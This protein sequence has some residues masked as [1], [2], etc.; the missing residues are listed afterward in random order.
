MVEL[1]QLSSSLAERKRR[2]SDRRLAH[3][4][5]QT[6]GR[7]ALDPESD[8]ENELLVLDDDDWTT[9]WIDSTHPMRVQCGKVQP[10]EFEQMLQ[11]GDGTGC[12]LAFAEHIDNLC[13]C[14]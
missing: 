4:V 5:V 9:L 11:S 6:C 7:L 3:D 1:L 10:E 14:S 2:N 12:C 8:E 13:I